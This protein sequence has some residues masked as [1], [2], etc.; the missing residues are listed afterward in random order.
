MTLTPLVRLYLA[1]KHPHRHHR[2]GGAPKESP[3][4]KEGLT[5]PVERDV[6]KI[7][8]MPDGHYDASRMDD[9]QVLAERRRVM[10]QC[11]L[12]YLSH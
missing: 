5:M 1:T 9:F 10:T 3:D 11:H 7:P 2:A 6:S 12:D 8:A 4:P